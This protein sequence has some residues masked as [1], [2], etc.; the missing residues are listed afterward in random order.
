MMKLWILE[1]SP[2]QPAMVIYD[3]SNGFVVRAEDETR[4][5]LLASQHKGDEG[6]STW[7]DPALSSCRELTV[8]GPEQMILRDFNAGIGERHP[9]TQTRAWVPQVD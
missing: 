4:A 2:F 3:A 8:D 6:A 5:R 9:E 1:R 7:M